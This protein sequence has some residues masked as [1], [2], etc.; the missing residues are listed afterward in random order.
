[1]LWAD[2][3]GITGEILSFDSGHRLLRAARLGFDDFGVQI[4]EGTQLTFDEQNGELVLSGG[5]MKATLE[6]LR[7]QSGG[8]AAPLRNDRM[9]ILCGGA[10]AGTAEFEVEG[11]GLT[12]AS[13][14]YFYGPAGALQRLVYPVFPSAQ[15][16][17][18]RIQ[19]C[20]ATNLRRAVIPAAPGSS[21][22]YPSCFRTPLGLEIELGTTGDSAIVYAYDP[23]ESGYY[24]I[25]DGHWSTRLRGATVQPPRIDL[26][27]GTSGLEYAKTSAESLVGWRYGG[28]AYAP[29]FAAGMTAVGATALVSGITGIAQE[30]TTAWAAFSAPGSDAGP[31][32]ASLPPAG[33][34]SQPSSAPFYGFDAGMAGVLQ[35]R[36]VYAG[37]FPANAASLPVAPYGGI[38]TEG[39]AP[40]QEFERQVL[41]A[42]RRQAILSSGEGPKGLPEMAPA[43][44]IPGATG[45]FGPTG[46]LSTMVTPRGI[47]AGFDETSGDWRQLT[48]VEADQGAQVLQFTDIRSPLRQTLLSNQLFAVISDTEKFLKTCSVRY[49]LTERSFLVLAEQ[50]VPLTVRQA[51]GPMLGYLYDNQAY[52]DA[53]LR[54]NLGSDFQQ[55]AGAFEQAAAIAQVVIRDWTFDLSP[56]LWNTKVISHIPHFQILRPLAGGDGKRSDSLELDRIPER[57][58]GGHAQNSAGHS[59]RCADPG[60]NRSRLPLLRRYR[61]PQPERIG[62]GGEVEWHGLPE[63]PRSG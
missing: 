53:A 40:F 49:R 56:Y 41:S 30:V 52:F 7:S 38:A 50:N 6:G 31:A 12:D 39:P 1:M 48:V 32:G 19:V 36:E 14:R 2:K 22:R 37:P 25:L 54:A 51:A 27:L 55:Y 62:R 42:V 4:P 13:V 24:P 10:G 3:S 35:F 57:C 47:L 63:L 20:A 34:Y 43:H 45:P 8:A 23:V 11:Q 33:Y 29:F 16:I 9:R 17:P 61:E 60:G 21:I 44:F 59:A 46:P 15:Q 18:L 5:G 28:P 26:M 58:A